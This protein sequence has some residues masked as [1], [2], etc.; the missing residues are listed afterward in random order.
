M[1]LDEVKHSQ[2][3]NKATLEVWHLPDRLGTCRIGCL[4]EI[5]AGSTQFDLNPSHV[6]L[7]RG[8]FTYDRPALFTSGSDEQMTVL[9]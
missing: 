3:A 1:K 4:T 9:D 6:R 5:G 8:K 2:P 7:F